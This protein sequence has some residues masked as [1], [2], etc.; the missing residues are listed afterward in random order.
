MAAPSPPW[1]TSILHQLVFEVHVGNPPSDACFC[2]TAA[3][4]AAA[5]PDRDGSAREVVLESCVMGLPWGCFLTPESFCALDNTRTGRVHEGDGLVPRETLPVQDTRYDRRRRRPRE[6]LRPRGEVRRELV[7]CFPPG[8]RMS[9]TGVPSADL[10]RLRL[11]RL[12]TDHVWTRRE[13][14]RVGFPRKR[15]VSV[16]ADR[17]SRPSHL[18]RSRRAEPL[19]HVPACLGLARRRSG[20][21][22]PA[23]SRTFRCMRAHAASAQDLIHFDARLGYLVLRRPGLLLGVR[24]QL[25]SRGDPMRLGVHSMRWTS[26][27]A[28]ARPTEMRPGRRDGRVHPPRRIPWDI[29]DG[30]RPPGRASL[31]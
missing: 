30:L 26:P 9:R 2:C 6:G 3:H 13:R 19:R 17:G 20:Q 15:G 29:I 21:P 7:S 12:R 22:N 25:L 24:Q 28:R 8:P 5:V 1:G 11:D 31:W 14:A 18:A 10:S 23:L 4:G 27:I 16:L